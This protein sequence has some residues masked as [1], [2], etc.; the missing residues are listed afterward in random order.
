[1]NKRNLHHI[2]TKAR[3]VKPRYVLILALCSSLVCLSS[4]RA[5]N[6]HM[7]KLRTAVYSADKS[8]GDI[9]S[10]LQNLQ[11]YVTTHMNTNLVTS[12]NAVYP[13][14]Q[15]EYTYQR[16]AQAQLSQISANNSQLYT[17]AQNY[18]QAL[19][20]TDFSGHNR[21]PCIESYVTS[22]SSLNVPPIPTALYEFDFVSPTWSP[23][24]AGW[25]LITTSLLGLIFLISLGLNWWL[26]DRSR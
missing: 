20:P 7:L 24:L 11:A 9:Q 12:A 10:S 3:L 17:N 14:I 19:D 1:M 5:N 2:W 4:L 16:L 13:P 25:S 21:V 15:L 22:H 26:K 18:C 23:D 8:G 6:E